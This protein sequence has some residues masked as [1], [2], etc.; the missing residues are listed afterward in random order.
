MSFIRSASSAW[1][2]CC[3]SSSTSG[4]EMLVTEKEAEDRWCP[5][6]LA[7]EGPPTGCAG[8]KCMAWR[9]AVEHEPLTEAEIAMAGSALGV[10]AA[11]KP[12]REPR[13]GYC[14]MAGKS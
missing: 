1:L 8:S 10:A 4:A 14:G 7:G 9:F 3:A 12:M 2:G 5:M 11:L 6:T 13:R